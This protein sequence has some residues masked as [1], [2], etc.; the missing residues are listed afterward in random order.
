MLVATL[1]TPCWNDISVWISSERCTEVWICLQH[2]L[3]CCACSDWG[4]GWVI[5]SLV[6]GAQGCWPHTSRSTATSFMSD[7]AVSV[8]VSWNHQWHTAAAGE[9]EVPSRCPTPV[10]KICWGSTTHD[11]VTCSI[12]RQPQAGEVACRGCTRVDEETAECVLR[13]L[14]GECRKCASVF[15]VK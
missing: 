3:V 10:G 12:V 4:A 7:R 9:A 6:A 1:K 2:R 11:R 15:T 14:F 13:G 5:Q 8:D